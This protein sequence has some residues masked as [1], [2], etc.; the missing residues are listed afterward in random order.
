MRVKKTWNIQCFNEAG[1]IMPRSGYNN[2]RGLDRFAKAS[3]RP[4]QSCPGVVRRESSSRPARGAAS[5]RPGQSCPGVA[6]PRRRVLC[7]GYECFNEAGAI[8]PRSGLEL[9]HGGR[10]TIVLQ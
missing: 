5:M 8:M 1:A 4:G 2:T 6:F 10:E 9:P 3:M 7:C